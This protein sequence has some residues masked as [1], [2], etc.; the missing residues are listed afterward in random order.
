MAAVVITTFALISSDTDSLVNKL[1]TTLNWTAFRLFDDSIPI[2][3]S[4]IGQAFL[5]ITLAAI[6]FVMLTAMTVIPRKRNLENLLANST[7][8]VVAAQLWYPE[9]VG[10]YVLWYL[11]LL[12]LVMFRPRLDRFVPPDQFDTHKAESQPDSRAATST[13]GA[14]PRVTLYH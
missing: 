12:L 2:S 8:L 3:S 14:L 13:G 5:R 7:A 10:T 6:F 1:V 9:D 4:A 11:P